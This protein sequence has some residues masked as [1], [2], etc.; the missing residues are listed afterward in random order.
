MRDIAGLNLKCGPALI[1]MNGIFQSSKDTISQSPEG[2]PA[3]VL[4]LVI[5]EPGKSE[6]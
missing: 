4:T 2:V 3:I 1:A 5:R 6:T